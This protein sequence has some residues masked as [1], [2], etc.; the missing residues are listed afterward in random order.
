LFRT[1]LLRSLKRRQA[2]VEID[3]LFSLL[4]LAEFDAVAE[5]KAR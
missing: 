4:A 1:N 2:K 5:E 3:Q